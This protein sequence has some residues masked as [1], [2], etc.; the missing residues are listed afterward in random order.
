[1]KIRQSFVTNSSSSS[2]VVVIEKDYF[3]TQIKQL[4]PYLKAVMKALKAADVVTTQ[5]FMGKDI[6]VFT[7]T[8]GNYSTMENIDVDYEPKDE[9]EEEMLDELKYEAI[10]KILELMTDTDKV[11]SNS[12]ES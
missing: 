11:L 7:Y 8:C 6:V 9:D 3:D 1:M 5:K 4:T 10:D 2:F 12:V